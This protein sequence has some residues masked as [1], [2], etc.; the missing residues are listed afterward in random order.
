LNAIQF[1]AFLWLR[2]RLLANQWRRGGRVNA[3]LMSILTIGAVLLAVPLFIG[4]FALGV[5]AIPRAAPVH[6][7]AV[8]DLIVIAFLFFWCIGL[9]AELQRSEP[10]TLSRFMHL[11]V[12]V[13]GAFLI[14]FLSSLLSLSLIVFLP[15]MLA[16][17]LSLVYVKG[18]SQWL[19][20]ALL[21]A[22]L[23]MVTALTYQLQGWL[24]S[25]MSNPRRRRTVVVIVTA[26]FILISQLPNLLN[27]FGP[28]GMHAQARTS[29]LAAEIARLDREARSPGADAEKIEQRRS[30]LFRQLTGT[31]QATRESLARWTETARLANMLLPIGWLPFGVMSAA[32]GNVLPSILGL[33]GMSL[34]GIASLRQAYRTTVAI[35]R[36]EP[37]NRRR[38]P[39]AALASPTPAPGTGRS[40]LEAR[41]PGVS[42]PVSAIALATLLSI[43][44]SPETKMMLLTP[45]IMVPIFGSM[46]LKQGQMIP[47]WARPLMGIG[48]MAI[49]LTGVMHFMMNQFGFDRDG[50]RTYVLCAAPR[51][52]I[53]LGKNLAFAP[54]SLGMSAILLVVLQAVAPMRLDHFL[55]MVS[56]NL[57]MYLVFC[58][59]ANLLSIY[60]PVHV[61]AG[62]LGP[63]SPNIKTVLLQLATTMILFPMAEALTLLPLGTEL[64]LGLFGRYSGVPICLVLTL[65]ECA[66]IAG[67]YRLTLTWQ[68]RLLQERE[69]EIL[70]RVTG[71]RV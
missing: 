57:S 53:L 65:V 49:A 39:A 38:K 25:L 44:R 31:N 2:W 46:L 15:I 40:R 19:T 42:E 55:A 3:V 66:V 37:T 32:E 26:S 29:A 50:F 10:L 8:W 20:P 58:I 28:F 12:S 24:A 36:G 16:F 23:L 62:S 69:Q 63:A 51:R 18:V 67:I 41:I 13:R 52:D 34:I 30:E 45:A 21:G 68:G 7:L 9:M 6:L 17:C 1:R 47:E 56:Q 14:N 48:A 70:D 61:P 22:F 59:L 33:L 71:R 11:P 43:Q 5:Y 4:G 64:V 60:A 27:F 35:Y 54:L